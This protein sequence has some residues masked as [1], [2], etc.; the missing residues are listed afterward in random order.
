MIGHFRSVKYEN[1]PT[2]GVFELEL[3]LDEK[4]TQAAALTTRCKRKDLVSA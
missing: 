3:K 4:S 2:L 1:G